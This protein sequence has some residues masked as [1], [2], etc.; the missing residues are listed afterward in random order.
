M[1][2]KTTIFTFHPNLENGSRINANL[3]KAASTAGFEVRDVYQLY[4]DFKIDVAAEQAALEAADRIVLQ[5]PIYWYQTPALLKQW[6]DAVLE[7]GWAYGSTGNALRGKEVILASS[8]GAALDDYQLEGR[9]HTT[10]EEVLKPIV[11]IQ[12]HTGLQFL[13]PFITTGT[14]KL[15]DANLSEQAEKFVEVLSAE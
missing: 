7:Y 2:L 4:P 8:F 12:Y 5:F 11:T 14:L 13:E 9:F 15:S 6:F 10:I 3:A 1:Q